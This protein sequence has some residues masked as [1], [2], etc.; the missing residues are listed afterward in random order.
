MSTS[1]KYGELGKIKNCNYYYEHPYSDR[2][3]VMVKEFMTNSHSAS[4]S[5]RKMLSFLIGRGWRDADNNVMDLTFISKFM[6][7]ISTFGGAFVLVDYDGNL[8]P[9]KYTVM[10]FEHMRVGILDDYQNYTKFFRKKAKDNTNIQS[11]HA[12]SGDVE[13]LKAQILTDYN[14]AN[15]TKDRDFSPEM[16]KNFSGQIAYCTTDDLEVYPFGWIG[17]ILNI[18]QAEVNFNDRLHSMSARS[19]ADNSLIMYDS[20]VITNYEVEDEGVRDQIDR[21]GKYMLKTVNVKD[22]MAEALKKIS[23][24]AH[25]GGSAVLPIPNLSQQDKVVQKIDLSSSGQSDEIEKNLN[26]IKAQILEGFCNIPPILVKTSESFF[27]PK[28]EDILSAMEVYEGNLNSVFVCC[29]QF[30]YKL[31]GLKYKPIKLTQGDNNI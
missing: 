13:E 5:R 3:G 29:E 21:N 20:N 25:A 11:F 24:P 2:F 14:K 16:I 9:C 12:F 26:I 18:C 23:D 7:S 19:F 28:G 17:A 30:F 4:M 10:P 8:S 27:A 15:N 6:G 1:R 22:E 31:F